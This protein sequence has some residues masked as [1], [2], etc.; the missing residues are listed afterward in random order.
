[1]HSHHN[2]LLG[3]EKLILVSKFFIKKKTSLENKKH[4][5]K[6]KKTSVMS[7][8]YGIISKETEILIRQ[9]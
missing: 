1:M 6:L 8:H 3:S 7:F 4:A 9:S 2:M 5:N